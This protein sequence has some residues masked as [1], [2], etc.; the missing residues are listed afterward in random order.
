MRLRAASPGARTVCAM[1][2]RLICLLA[3]LAAIGA[4]GAGS[5]PLRGCA[6]RAAP[7]PSG[8]RTREPVRR[9]RSRPLRR[10]AGSRFANNE[11]DGAQQWYLTQDNAWSYWPAPPDLPTVKVAVIDTGIDASHPEFVGRI[12]AGRS[13]VSSSWRVGHLRPRHLRRGRDRRQPVQRRGDR[14]ACL[15]RAAAGREGRPVGLHRL[16]D[17][18]DPRDPLGSQRGRPR[19]QLQPRRQPRPARPLDR[20]VLAPGAGRDR[21][22]GLEGRARGRR[23]RERPRGA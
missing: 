6:V 21:V 23:L 5:A 13:F 12:A 15:Q 17:R 1:A 7:R 22:R 2:R 11:P 18:R 4:G 3:L 14:R 8:S 10:R 16:D 19:D 9:A 20:R